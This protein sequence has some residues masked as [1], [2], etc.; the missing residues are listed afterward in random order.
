ML[1]DRPTSAEEAIE[2]LLADPWLDP[3]LAAHRVLEPQ[4]PR[5]APWPAEI[6][7]R[8]ATALRVRGVEALYTH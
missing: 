6:D 3:L 8:L 4:P 2:A 1:L 5:Y 7:P